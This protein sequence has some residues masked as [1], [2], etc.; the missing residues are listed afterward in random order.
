M[1]IGAVN[2]I[3]ERTRFPPVVEEG[4]VRLS[5]KASFIA[6]FVWLGIGGLGEEGRKENILYHSRSLVAG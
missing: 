1:I 4:K 5:L 6:F 2:I 3:G